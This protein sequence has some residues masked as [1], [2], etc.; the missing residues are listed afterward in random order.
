[1]GNLLVVPH[2]HLRGQTSCRLCVES[3]RGVEVGAC[4]RC[5][6]AVEHRVE[7]EPETVCLNCGHR[8]RPAET[9]PHV[10]MHTRV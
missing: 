1:M 5:G 6:G 2:M 8:P 10:R 7:M 4:E 3:R 9:L